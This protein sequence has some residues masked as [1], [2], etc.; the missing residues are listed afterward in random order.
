MTAPATP[1][2]PERRRRRTVQIFVAV[3]VLVLLLAPVVYLFG[4]LWSST[5]SAMEIAQTERAAVAYAR[6]LHKLLAALVDA[7]SAAARETAVDAPGVRAVVDEVDAVDA[8][9]RQLTDPLQA[10][11]RWNQLRHEID[12]TLT[13]NP[14]G[15]EALRGYAAP[16]A[17]TQALLARI[18]DASK[19]T[20]DPGVGSYRLIDVALQRLPDAV[21]SAGQVAALASISD[22]PPPPGRSSRPAGQPDPRLAVAVDRLIQAA[23]QVGIG[24]RAGTNPEGTYGVDLRLLELLDEFAAAM[25]ELSQTAAGLDVPGSGARDRIDAVSDRAKT[26]A[27]ALGTAV[28]NAFDTQL[29]ANARGYT[30][31]RRILV[32]SG[33]VIV[34]AAVALLWLR[35]PGPAAPPAVAPEAP[36]EKTE[37]RHGYPAESEDA[38]ADGSQ[39]IPKL[40]D[41]RELLAP[42]L[43]PAGRVVRV[44]KRQDSDDH[45]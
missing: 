20:G 24:L 42:E 8:V 29:G 28:L 33:V 41:A 30:M 3:L 37:G 1:Q 26:A 11:Q 10:R 25:D 35:V 40:V 36:V 21:A 14:S 4:Q 15:S 2:S 39:G 44:M 17:L 5:G 31:Q 18:A 27:L 34:L 23:N 16:I 12:S 13:Q 22:N 45:Q 9:D 19:V 32:L 6:P 7:Q 38:K 43:V